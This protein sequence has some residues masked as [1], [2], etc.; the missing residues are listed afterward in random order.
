MLLVAIN[1][2]EDG[3]SHFTFKDVL[4]IKFIRGQLQLSAPVKAQS[5]LIHEF[6]EKFRMDWHNPPQAQ[7]VVV[8]D[9]E[10]QVELKDNTAKN[11][12]AGEMFLSQDLTGTGHRTTGIKPG[13]C[14]IVNLED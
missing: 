8:L 6:D 9:G 13:K 11:F 5:L 10:L 14:L 3:I 1:S 12:K 2:K 7:L 4:P